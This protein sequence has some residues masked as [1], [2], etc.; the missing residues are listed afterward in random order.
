MVAWWFDPRKL[1][2]H[3]TTIFCTRGK[4]MHYLKRLTRKNGE[5]GVSPVVGV[6]L[7]LVVTII[8][9]AVVSGFSGSL[10]DGNNAKAPSLMIDVKISNTG[11]WVGSGFTA[12]VTSVSDPIP[13][14]NIKLVTS[15]KTTSRTTG[16]TISGG[17]TSMPLVNNV[18]SPQIVTGNACGTGLVSSNAPYGTGSGVTGGNG[19]QSLTDP[20]EQPAQQFGNYTLTQGTGL[21]ALPYGS[22]FANAI[23]TSSAQSDVGG[24]GIPV[25]NYG[26]GPYKYTNGGAFTRGTVDATQAVLGTGWENLKAGDMVNVKVIHIQTGK[27]IVDKDVTVTEG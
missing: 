25:S 11:N 7:M 18:V 24:Y 5:D 9:A 2:H 10:I 16:G 3:C 20:F 8:I 1:I 17:N 26:S 19:A 27:V 23:G 15:W 22:C 14:K 21:V 4:N 12:T 13:T 6:M